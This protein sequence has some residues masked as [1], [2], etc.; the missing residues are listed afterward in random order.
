M[1]SPRLTTVLKSYEIL[2][3]LGLNVPFYIPVSSD[4][5]NKTFDTLDT[6]KKDEQ[7]YTKMS[8]DIA[9]RFDGAP[10]CAPLNFY[11]TVYDVCPECVYYKPDDRF[12]PAWL[13]KPHLIGEYSKIKEI[14]AR[15]SAECKFSGCIDFD[16]NNL[17]YF[18]TQQ[19]GFN[20]WIKNKPEI[21][22][23]LGRKTVRLLDEGPDVYIEN[24]KVVKGNLPLKI[25]DDITDYATSAKNVCE[26]NKVGNLIFENSYHSVESG[27]KRNRVVTW[28]ILPDG[29]VEGKK[30]LLKLM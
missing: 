22:I 17:H 1:I 23:V 4:N 7:G 10:S 24:G 20:I 16:M 25:K 13:K 26:K 8:R 11:K 19:A 21:E 6:I 2:E 30:S 15:T 14:L 18:R 9:M 5:V 12:R 28:D 27:K 3:R 29:T